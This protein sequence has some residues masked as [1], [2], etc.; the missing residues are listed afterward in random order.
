MTRAHFALAGHT[1]ASRNH[2]LP[3]VKDYTLLLLRGVQ[4]KSHCN[5]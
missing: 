3:Q 2:F 4:I 1:P 5:Y